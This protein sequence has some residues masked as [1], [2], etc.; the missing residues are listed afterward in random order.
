MN[1]IKN[2][3]TK[4][5]KK[6]ASELQEMQKN[7]F[8]IQ[9]KK[10][11]KKHGQTNNE[12]EKEK[13]LIYNKELWRKRIQQKTQ[14][15]QKNNIN[16]LKAKLLHTWKLWNN[17]QK[18]VKIRENFTQKRMFNTYEKTYIIT[19]DNKSY[20]WEDYIIQSDYKNINYENI[21]KQQLLK[22]RT[23]GDKLA[24]TKNELNQL[25]QVY[26]NRWIQIVT[27]E[28]RENVKTNRIRLVWRRLNQLKE[29]K[30]VF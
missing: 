21:K 12:K 10:M 26:K 5:W 1:T 15:I 7:K 27:Q 11:P 9:D 20:E 18:S 23:F 13:T 25:Q 17:I 28:I 30:S 3:N 16:E 24:Q 19:Y 14:Q 6:L 4:A 2:W 8:P 22:L 29:Q